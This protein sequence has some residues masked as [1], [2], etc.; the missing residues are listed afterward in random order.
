[1]QIETLSSGNLFKQSQRDMNSHRRRS[2][3]LAPL[4]NHR[5]LLDNWVKFQSVIFDLNDHC[6]HFSRAFA[7]L[8]NWWICF[9]DF[10]LN[11]ARTLSIHSRIRCFSN[12][13]KVISTQAFLCRYHAIKFQFTRSPLIGLHS[14]LLSKVSLPFRSWCLNMRNHK[15]RLQHVT[16]LLLLNE[17]H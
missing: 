15:T 7:F 5:A 8:R 3:F 10:Q 12:L 11:P 14:K 4:P 13:K 16:Q 1:M 9:N 6:L 17:R 2:L